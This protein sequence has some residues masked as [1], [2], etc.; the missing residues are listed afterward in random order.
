M[1]FRLQYTLNGQTSTE[2]VATDFAKARKRANKLWEDGATK[3]VFIAVADR[4]VAK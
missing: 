2:T 1:K 4:K 3:V